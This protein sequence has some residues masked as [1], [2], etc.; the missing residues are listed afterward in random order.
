MRPA[1]I[2][3]RGHSHGQIGLSL[4]LELER[5]RL[6]EAP[7]V[8]TRPPPNPCPSASTQMRLTGPESVSRICSSVW[9]ALRPAH[10][11][12]R[13]WQKGQGGLDPSRLVA[14]WLRPTV[15]SLFTGS[16]LLLGVYGKSRCKRSRHGYDGSQ[17]QGACD[18]GDCFPEDAP[19]RP[20]SAV[21]QC[22]QDPLIPPGAEKWK[23]GWG[24]PPSRTQKGCREDDL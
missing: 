15:T 2:V 5:Q 4:R 9:P 1:Q 11:P 23:C 21:T 20:F 10:H 18:H 13:Y 16:T 12:L 19:A 6:R 17:A 24:P 8:R 3:Q 14:H 7:A 22:V